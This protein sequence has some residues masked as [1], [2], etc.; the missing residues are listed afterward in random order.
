MKVFGCITKIKYVGWSGGESKSK[1]FCEKCP[2]GVDCATKRNK[3][4]PLN[5]EHLCP[6]C[7]L[8][9]RGSYN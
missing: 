2:K 4:I 5:K 3:T 6:S 1:M 8:A 9:H 7:R